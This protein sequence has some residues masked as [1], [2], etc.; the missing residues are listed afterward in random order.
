MLQNA[1][2]LLQM[3][4]STVRECGC[5]HCYKLRHAAEQT[6]DELGIWKIMTLMLRHCY[7]NAT[8]AISVLQMITFREFR[9]FSPWCRFVLSLADVEIHD[10]NWRYTKLIMIRV[11]FMIAVIV[12]I[13]TEIV[14]NKTELDVVFSTEFHIHHLISAA[15]S[16]RHS[17]AVLKR[18]QNDIWNTNC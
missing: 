2:A 6:V 5:F 8:N 14:Q 16:A 3:I 7:N 4:M 15:M 1:I 12:N 9:C 17:L 11:L 10:D 13:N 18:Y